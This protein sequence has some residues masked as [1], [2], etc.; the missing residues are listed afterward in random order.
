MMMNSNEKRDKR[1]SQCEKR[2]G[3]GAGGEVSARKEKTR[4]R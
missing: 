4:R 1:R 2:G 3:E